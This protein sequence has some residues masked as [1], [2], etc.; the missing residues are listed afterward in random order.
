MSTIYVKAFI[1]SK[2]DPKVLG[3]SFLPLMSAA[4]ENNTHYMC[5][6]YM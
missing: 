1:K 4:Q 2:I 5:V 3:K 6:K